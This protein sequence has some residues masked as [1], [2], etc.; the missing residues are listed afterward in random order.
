[1]TESGGEKNASFKICAAENG[2][3]YAVAT[4]DL[5]VPTKAN[6]DT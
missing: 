5:K 3:S 4:L 6:L 2:A 1:M